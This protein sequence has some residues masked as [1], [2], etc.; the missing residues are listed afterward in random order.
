MNLRTSLVT[1]GVVA[2]LGFLTWGLV[3][4]GDA[5]LKVGEPV[6]AATLPD[7]PPGGES[8]IEDYRGQW[9]LLNIW[10]SWCKPC[11]AE[12]PALEEFEQKHRGEVTVL[13]VNTRDL[14]D[15][16]MKFLR[17]YEIGYP[18]I[19]DASGD[20]ADELKATGVPESILIDPDGNLAS[21]YPGPFR[22]L[23]G[24]EAFAAPALGGEPV[25]RLGS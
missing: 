16:A 22:D 23:A 8:S 13:G 18:Q 20:Y 6:P 19:R 1:V 9:V 7:L 12:S 24:V 5:G 2:L 4:K 15:D 25:E 21:H 11:R 14:S 3:N 17:E 10:A